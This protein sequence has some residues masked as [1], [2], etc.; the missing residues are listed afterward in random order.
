MV[1]F[2]VKSRKQIQTLWLLNNQKELQSLIMKTIPKFKNEIF[3]RISQLM[4]SNIELLD[5]YIYDDIHKYYYELL[6]TVSTS[7]KFKKRYTEK[8]N[9]YLKKRAK[10]RALDIVH[11]LK[12]PQFEN[13]KISNYLDLGANDG[14]ITSYLGYYLGLRKKNIIALDIDNQSY[15]EG[16][17]NKKIFQATYKTYDGEH[18]PFPANTFDVITAFMCL[19]HV[20]NQ[21][22]IIHELYR[23]IKKNGV[24]II[25]EHNIKSDEERMI[26]DIQHSLYEMVLNSKPIDEFYDTFKIE[27]NS[28]KDWDNLFGRNK[29]KKVYIHQ[30]STIKNNPVKYYYAVYQK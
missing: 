6:N 22:D 20:E 17:K 19:H 2:T 10:Y 30:P 16:V 28:E 26:A 3:N 1:Y 29:F 23:V 8:D 21:S 15:Y 5:N 13:L 27:C 4:N 18:I 9:E 24:I 7:H 11:I 14:S 25:R 12:A